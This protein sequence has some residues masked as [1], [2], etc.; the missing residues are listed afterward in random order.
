MIEALHFVLVL[1]SFIFGPSN[2]EPDAKS[3]QRV[4]QAISDVMSS[5]S[6]VYYPGAFSLIYKVYT[7]LFLPSRK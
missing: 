3:H 1:V 6:A 5:N 4:C 7:S 2:V